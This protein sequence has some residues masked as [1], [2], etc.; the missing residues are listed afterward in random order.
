[1]NIVNTVMWYA[2][3]AGFLLF[4]VL[5][6]LLVGAMQRNHPALYQALGAP[7]AFHFLLYRRDFISHPYTA[8]IL[9]REYREKL[10]PFRE[11]RQ[12]AQAI[13]A[14]ALV[15]LT[16]GATLWLVLPP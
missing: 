7:S 6:Y 14:C 9:R 11:L 5:N 10:T 3:G 1:M 16:A 13:F 15:C 12:I 8:L 2:F 4:H